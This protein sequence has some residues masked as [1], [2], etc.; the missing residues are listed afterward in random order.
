MKVSKSR[1]SLVKITLQGTAIILAALIG[2][3]LFLER[4]FEQERAA[5]A[6]QQELK[7]L[8]CDLRCESDFLTLHVRAQN[9]TPS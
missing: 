5:L 9:P 7:Q 6:H 1:T 3:V 8:G 2:S 4:C